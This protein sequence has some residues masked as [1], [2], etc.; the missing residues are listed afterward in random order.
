MF[1]TRSVGESWRWMEVRWKVWRRDFLVALLRVEFYVVEI[2]QGIRWTLLSN[3]CLGFVLVIISL[4]LRSKVA[5][6]CTSFK[7]YKDVYAPGGI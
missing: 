3:G 6:I 7:A 5:S 2:M 1:D 4:C